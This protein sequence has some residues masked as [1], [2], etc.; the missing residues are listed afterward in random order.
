MYNLHANIGAFC[1]MAGSDK[2]V[3]FISQTT[4]EFKV[5][6]ESFPQSSFIPT[7]KLW[8]N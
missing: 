6:N 3:N 8:W 7:W 4:Q 2:D 1:E 5:G